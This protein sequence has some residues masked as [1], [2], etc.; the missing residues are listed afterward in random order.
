[1]ELEQAQVS[2]GSAQA[3]HEAPVVAHATADER[4][5][6]ITRTYV[7]LFAAILSFTALE[8]F[9]FATPMAGVMIKILTASRFAWIAFIAAFV[10]VSYFADKWAQTT[11]SKA[12]Q[13]AG[14][15]LYTLFESILFLPMIALALVAGG[16]GD[17]PILPRAIAITATLFGSLTGVVFVTRKDF[18]FMRGILMFCGLAAMGLVVASILFGFTL[19][20]AFSYAMVA[21]ACGYILYNTSNIMLRY[22]TNQ[23]AAAALALF[24]DVMLLFW[25][26]LRIL[27]SRR[28]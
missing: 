22:R 25:Y 17:T 28:N 24:A 27:S 23:H 16:A 8:M 26:V 5:A 21:L 12:A 20:I 18:S 3:A 11:T 1:M 10:G 7:W 13:V 4:A 2:A 9:W 6:F 15:G 14:L 19:G